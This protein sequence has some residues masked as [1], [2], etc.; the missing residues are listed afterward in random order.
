MIRFSNFKKSVLSA[1]I[2]LSIVSALPACGLTG[3]GA[4]DSQTGAGTSE[5]TETAS[6]AV[7]ESTAIPEDS[8]STEI[9]TAYTALLDTYVTALNER[10]DSGT[11]AEKGLNTM[12]SDFY[13]MSNIDISPLDSIGYSVIDLDGNGTPELI[14]GSTASVSDEFYGKLILELYTQNEDGAPVEVFGSMARSRYYY[15]GGRLF[16]WLASNSASDSTSTTMSYSGAELTDT[17]EVV[18]PSD[19]AQLELTP[20]SGLAVK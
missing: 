17:G 1:V 2:L 18:D 19:Y 20:L 16:A 13:D 11:L 7:A 5:S 9:P 6:T 3:Q 15:A 4:G 12:L 8:V 10:W 14:L